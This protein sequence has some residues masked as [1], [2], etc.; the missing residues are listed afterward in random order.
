MGRSTKSGTNSINW[1]EK[2]DII[3]VQC[4]LKVR[5]DGVRANGD[6][7]IHA[8][9]WRN[10]ANLFS[11]ATKSAWECNQ[12]KTHWGVLKNRMKAYEKLAG[13]SGSGGH[14]PFFPDD[15]DGWDSALAYCVE[16]KYIKRMHEEWELYPLLKEAFGAQVNGSFLDAQ[17]GKLSGLLTP[18]ADDHSALNE[19]PAT[20]PS[21]VRVSAD[22]SFSPVS[23]SRKRR[24]SADDDVDSLLSPEQ[25]RQ[26]DK[27][28]KRRERTAETRAEKSCTMQINGWIQMD[29]KMQAETDM[30]NDWLFELCERQEVSMECAQDCWKMP[31]DQRRWLMKFPDERRKQL[32]PGYT[33]PREEVC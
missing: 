5:N 7:G 10:V 22:A 13:M 28:R 26:L 23:S 31:Q 15:W 8:V 19:V 33:A 1:N 18:P 29:V 25:R 11:R 20:A 17:L 2:L 21:P 6:G 30:F 27:N 16:M 9:A 4:Y 3:L 32:L 14:P 24:C 12:A